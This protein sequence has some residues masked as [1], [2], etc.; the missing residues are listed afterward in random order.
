[1][2]VDPAS[3]DSLAQEF[4][5]A[6]FFGGLEEGLFFVFLFRRA[7]SFTYHQVQ[8][9]RETHNHSFDIASSHSTYHPKRLL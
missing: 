6:T 5:V 7:R 2:V 1:M 4:P 8:R 9:T 3:A